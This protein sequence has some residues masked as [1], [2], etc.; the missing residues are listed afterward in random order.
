MKTSSLLTVTLFAA[1]CSGAADVK[2]DTAEDPQEEGHTD[3]GT[4]E[5]PTE[6]ANVN[7]MDNGDVVINEVLAKSDNTDDWIEIYNKGTSTVDLSGWSITDDA[8]SE[9]VP[10]P[11]P[12]GTTIEAGGFLLIWAND[13]DG[14]DLSA[15]FKMSKDGETV[16]IY[17]GNNAISSE[18]T[19]PALEDEES[20]VRTSDGGAEW[21]IS[22]DSTPGE[23]NE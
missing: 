20:A 12:A 22:M 6:T 21:V 1:A 15:D 3:T 18:V 2:E 7:A 13:G 23:S 16:T 17:D 10:W 9:E 8:G 11:F 14:G 19:F 5:E 4:T